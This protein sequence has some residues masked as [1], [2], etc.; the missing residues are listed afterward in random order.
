MSNSNEK[1]L[2]TAK[3]AVADNLSGMAYPLFPLDENG[4]PEHDDV[5]C[6]PW[7]VCTGFEITRAEIDIE[8]TNEEVIYVV[9][10]A[11]IQ[12]SGRQGEDEEDEEKEDVDYG[13]EI[14]VELNPDLILRDINY[15]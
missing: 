5:A 15:S 8:Q 10:T 4:R 1:I 14:Q 2:Q 6:V 9:V 13:V 11:D 3:Q 12:W 7:R